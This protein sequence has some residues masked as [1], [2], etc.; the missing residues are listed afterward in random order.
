MLL[1]LGDLQQMVILTGYVPHDLKYIIN[2]NGDYQMKFNLRTFDSDG[3][4][5][6][7]QCMAY[8]DIAIKIVDQFEKNDSIVIWGEIKHRYLRKCNDTTN[9]V[10]VR[11]YSIVSEIDLVAKDGTLK[12]E[13]QLFLE[14]C[15]LKF[16]KNVPEPTDEEVK[17]W[18]E[19]Y[20]KKYRGR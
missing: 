9:Y 5:V 18:R 15:A 16:D 8:G 12:E 4:P 13:K 2:G 17:E 11:A 3:M 20:R 6:L 14:K 19:I 7:V 10:K 1:Q